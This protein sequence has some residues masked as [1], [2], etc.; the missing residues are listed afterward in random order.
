MVICELGVAF[1]CTVE[2]LCRVACWGLW[3]VL[4]N[5][6]AGKC[7]VRLLLENP[8]LQIFRTGTMVEGFTVRMHAE[9]ENLL[10]SYAR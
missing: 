6:V 9:N 7:L 1:R 3:L 10:S 5:N 8:S 2:L 4:V